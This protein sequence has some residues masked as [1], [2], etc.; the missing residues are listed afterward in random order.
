MFR[1]QNP[2]LIIEICDR[3]EV[4]FVADEVITGF[5]RTGK[6]FALEH[7]GI[8]PDLVQFAIASLVIGVNLIADSLAVAR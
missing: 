4:L 6:M 2:Y 7:Y 3:Y 5:G 8:Q 1:Y